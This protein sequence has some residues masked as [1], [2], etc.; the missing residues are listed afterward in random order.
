[1]SV[2]NAM[3]AELDERQGRS[4]VASVFSGVTASGRTPCAKRRRADYRYAVALVLFLLLGLLVMTMPNAS[5]RTQISAPSPSMAK[6]TA[7]EEVLNSQT[8]TVSLK[9]ATYI[10]SLSESKPQTNS[11]STDGSRVIPNVTLQVN[12][13]PKFETLSLHEE[14]VQAELSFAL[15]RDLPYRV[16]LQSDPYR[17]VVVWPNV[18]TS[19]SPASI[20]DIAGKIVLRGQTRSAE[21]EALKMV[22][23]LAEPVILRAT[24]MQTNSEGARLAIRLAVTPL[25]DGTHAPSPL[26]E[27]AP[28]NQPSV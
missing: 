5:L 19:S 20:H 12:E 8:N 14:D 2:I 4:D 16:F 22:F 25:T 17:L 13:V 6:P 21:H 23:D 9:T 3:L 1:M 18:P 24:K 11:A 7:P 15:N 27:L 10:E 28:V 26:A